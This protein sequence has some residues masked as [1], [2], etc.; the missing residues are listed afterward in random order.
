MF[1]M[2]ES[3][4]DTDDIRWSA[5]MDSIIKWNVTGRAAHIYSACTSTEVASEIRD[6]WEFSNGV[7]SVTG[8][9]G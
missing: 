9:R 3:V 7:G 1:E 5:I 8:P 6:L 2:R 4:I